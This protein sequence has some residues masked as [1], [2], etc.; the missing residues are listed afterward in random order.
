MILERFPVGMMGANCYIIGCEETKE[1]CVIDPGDEDKKILSKL[2][3]HG[4]TCRYIV[5]THGHV[6]HIGALEQVQKATG[7]R[8]LIHR[9]DADMLTN[10]AKNLSSFMGLQMQ[11]EPADVKLGDKDVIEVGKLKLEVI[12]T[13]GHTPGGICLKTGDCLITG[14]TLFA[15][16]VGR[17]DFPG[18]SHSQLIASIKNKLLNFPD[19][20]RVFSGHGPETSIGTE[21]R[22]NPFL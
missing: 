11:F 5:L 17:S 7:A 10:P 3:K 20:T 13:P 16:S 6:D 19:N 15:G 12:H 2:V 9:D 22:T 4:L 21:K 8:V 1:A 14:D 18:G